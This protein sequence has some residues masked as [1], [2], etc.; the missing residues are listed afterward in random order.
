MSWRPIRPLLIAL[1][2]VVAM[3]SRAEATIAVYAS[4]YGSATSSST[5]VS[6]Q[7]WTTVA[8]DLIVCSVRW[9]RDAGQNLTMSDTLTHTYTQVSGSPLAN[10]NDYMAV[11]Y[12]ENI[13]G[14]S[15][16]VTGTLSGAAS[17]KAIVCLE[18]SDAKT[19][20]SLDTSATATIG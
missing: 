20:S 17:N 7:G 12:V 13:S 1:L 19:S 8:A 16:T 2:L 6:T 9:T 15:N 18:I 11:Y 4:L 14:G 5:T 3:A 10:S